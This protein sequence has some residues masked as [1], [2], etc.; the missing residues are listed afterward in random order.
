MIQQSNKNKLLEEQENTLEE[1]QPL[2]ELLKHRID[3]DL[4]SNLS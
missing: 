2:I 3:L 1:M 4:Q